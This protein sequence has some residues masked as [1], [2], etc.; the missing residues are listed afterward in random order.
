MDSKNKVKVTDQQS[1]PVIIAIAMKKGEQSLQ[2]S[3]EQR[4]QKDVSRELICFETSKQ[5]IWD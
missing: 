3:Y 4:S 1:P 5:R 2:I